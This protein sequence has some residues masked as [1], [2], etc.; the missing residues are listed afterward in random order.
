[1]LE[2]KK[3]KHR[4]WPK[5]SNKGIAKKGVTLSFGEFG[6]QALSNKYITQRQIESARIT[7]SHFIKRSG[8]MWINIFPYKPIT[9]KGIEVPMGGGKGD[10]NGFVAPVKAGRILFEMSGV[11]ENQAKEAFRLA[12]HKLPVRSRFVKR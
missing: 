3:V 7:I 5:G 11:S 8:K 12:S 2:P 4:K 6:L 10:I 1:M 9:T